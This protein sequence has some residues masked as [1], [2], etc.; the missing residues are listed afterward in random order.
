MSTDANTNAL[1]R[2]IALREAGDLAAALQAARDAA[3]AEPE[4]PEA[5][6]A[7][8]EAAMALGDNALAVDGFAAALRLA[9]GWPSAW[10]NLGLVR[11]RQ[12]A[13][14]I[15]KRCMREA[16]RFAP[17]HPAATANLA[18]LMR[19]SGETE[20]AEA[21]L[22]QA[23]AR[24]PQNEAARLN[25]VAELI[26]QGN[27]AQAL[28]LLDAA[29]NSPQG[30]SVEW[31]LAR[32]LALL[33]Q[34]QTRM[35]RLELAALSSLGPLPPELMPL[36]CWRGVLLA[37]Q[38]GNREEAINAARHMAAALDA[39][40]PAAVPE[41]RL[42]AHYDLASFWMRQGDRAAAFA[43]WQAGHDLLRQ[44]QPYSRDAHRN[45]IDATI[46]AFSGERLASGAKAA[47]TDP[48]PVFIVGMP[49]SGTTLCEQILAAHAQVHGA[50][51]RT[52]LHKLAMRLGGPDDVETP[53]RIAAL[54]AAA[55]DG[56]AGDY[57]AELHALAPD[58][59]R[60]VDKMP[61]NELYLGVIGLTMPAAKIIHCVRDPR[62]IGFSIW[63]FRFYGQHPYAHDLGDLGWTIAQRMRLM[64]HWHDALPNPVLTVALNDWID[65]FDQTLARVLAHL[66]L[67]HDPAC[68]RFYEVD[69]K[70][71][72]VSRD[73]VRQP[74]NAKGIGRWRPYAAQ[75][76]PLIDELESAGLIAQWD[77]RG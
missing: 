60:I 3:A 55:L 21:L 10:I 77:A 36:F 56:A 17:G 33:Q 73:Q 42:M 51:E 47:N 43:H 72:T 75:L 25:L 63:T 45:Y 18:A 65:D 38:E 70:V 27:G 26:Q 74:I 67:P 49:R 46:A 9:A 41:H 44:S 64:A 68:A 23:V 28:E 35:A 1:S 62:D 13:V 40:G 50:G 24:A 61:G 31:R 2:Y 4:L 19:I 16:L 22:H 53:G 39:M 69:R 30:R 52:A 54:D 32:S 29:P 20:P 34:G 7:V 8:G 58:K 48:A 57:L 14:D 76:T 5:H 11:Y 37:Q 6:Y 15:A 12:G 59:A 66:E 71:R